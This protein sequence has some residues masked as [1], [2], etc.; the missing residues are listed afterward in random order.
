M[1]C[2]NGFKSAFIEWYWE[3]SKYKKS[4]SFLIKT[5]RICAIMFRPITRKVNE[6]ILKTCTQYKCKL[7]RLVPSRRKILPKV[8]YIT[9]C[10]VAVKKIYIKLFIAWTLFLE[11]H[12]KFSFWGKIFKPEISEDEQKKRRYSHLEWK[13]WFGLVSL[14]AYQPL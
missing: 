6:K 12:K 1:T 8:A 10:A 11:E 13:V 5:L 3:N 4:F 2:R 7:L 14:M 9:F